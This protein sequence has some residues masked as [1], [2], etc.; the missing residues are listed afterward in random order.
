MS[1]TPRFTN[2]Y[3][4]FNTASLGNVQQSG[5]KTTQDASLVIYQYCLCMDLH[6][7]VDVAV[8]NGYGP[9]L[10]SNI[11][12][13]LSA[14]LIQVSNAEEITSLKKDGVY[15]FVDCNDAAPEEDSPA[16][17][18][19]ADVD[20]EQRTADGMFSPRPSIPKEQKA[21]DAPK[22]E[23]KGAK[24]AAVSDDSQNLKPK[25]LDWNAL[26]DEEERI[27]KAIAKAAAEKAAAEKEITKTAAEKRAKLTWSDRI[28]FAHVPDSQLDDAI[29]AEKK[30][31]QDAEKAEA[32]KA[33]AEK[34]AAEK[35]AAGKAAAEKAEAEK[36]AIHFKNYH[37]IPPEKP[38]VSFTNK[39]VLEM[40]ADEAAGFIKVGDKNR[41]TVPKFVSANLHPEKQCTV[42]SAKW[43]FG[44][45][46]PIM[47]QKDDWHLWD[48]EVD[49]QQR[50]TPI[51]WIRL[52]EN[53]FK[54]NRS[55]QFVHIR[56]EDGSWT[57]EE[58]IMDEKKHLS[59]IPVS[60][61]YLRWILTPHRMR[62]GDCP[63]M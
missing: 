62:R 17:N 49:D 58:E 1:N 52:K 43:F 44:G 54:I 24:S 51:G 29:N 59:R 53:Q 55:S 19:S 26:M 2:A 7:L 16:M 33:A 27:E 9:I 61:D 22:K 35:A 28:Q 32:E 36:A 21:P 4:N 14:N 63:A 15:N 5:C 38:K 60:V 39:D 37:S 25:K 50:I 3:V 41:K 47:P 40:L 57:H 42:T 12:A 45:Q 48:Y 18:G 31:V 46:N 23:N 8:A 11:A 34:A 6:E 56:H 20:V 13:A 10:R 30:R